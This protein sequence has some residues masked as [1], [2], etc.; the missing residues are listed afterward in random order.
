MTPTWNDSDLDQGTDDGVVHESTPNTG[1]DDANEIRKGDPTASP[2]F[3]ADLKAW[4]PLQETGGGTAYDFSGNNYDGSINGATPADGVNLTGLPTYSFDGTDDYIGLGRDFDFNGS[5]TVSC[6]ARIPDG[7]DN[8][9]SIIDPYDGS[10]DVFRLYKQDSSRD[11]AVVF[12][13][14][15]GNRTRPN[16][17]VTDGQWRH[18]TGVYDA[19]ALKTR[20]YYDAQQKDSKNAPEPSNLPDNSSDYAIGRR[21]D[22][23]L[24]WSG[25]IT[26]VRIYDRALTD[27]EIQEL[28]G[29]FAAPSSHTSTKK[30][31]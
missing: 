28:Y 13:I 6:W 20:L 11:N 26:D 31:L 23:I 29:V 25:N 12:Q 8:F 9:A 18:Y 4:Y 17:D 14:G 2:L 24:Y 7:E 22:G 30:Q 5:F 21:Q 1:Y 27:S 10:Y 16:I 3:A 19:D 15:S